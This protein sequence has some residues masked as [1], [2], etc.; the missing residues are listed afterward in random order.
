M[1]A[2]RTHVGGLGVPVPPS[3]DE[4]GPTW[5]TQGWVSDVFSLSPPTTAVL[6]LTVSSNPIID[7]L[8]EVSFL[9]GEK[10]LWGT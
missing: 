10:I 4:L 7:N 2:S 8:T 3:P 5:A 6:C 9:E 1:T